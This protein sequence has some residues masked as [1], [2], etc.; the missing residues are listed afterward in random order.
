M[1]TLPIV[2]EGNQKENTR[3]YISLYRYAKH[4]SFH[5][6][7]E[8]NVPEKWIIIHGVLSYDQV[9]EIGPSL[10][11]SKKRINYAEGIKD[12]QAYHLNNAIINR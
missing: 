6:S 10:K 11:N 1:E 4:R 12:R 5:W 9:E 8:R 7:L 2:I 3:T